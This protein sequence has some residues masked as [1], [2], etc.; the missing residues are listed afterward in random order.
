MQ[1]K[2][3]YKFFIKS[4]YETSDENAIY[5]YEFILLRGMELVAYLNMLKNKHDT[6]EK[7]DAFEIEYDRRMLRNTI[8]TV[9]NVNSN[10]NQMLENYE[11]LV[12]YL[13]K[14]PLNDSN[15]FHVRYFKSN[16]FKS[17]SVIKLCP[18]LA[19][20]NAGR[21]PDDEDIMMS[22][23]SFKG[24]NSSIYN[25]YV[26]AM[27]RA[28]QREPF[29]R[30]M[31]HDDEKAYY[32]IRCAG[33]HIKSS[34]E[35]RVYEN[36]LSEIIDLM[37]K[38]NY[39]YC[40]MIGLLCLNFNLYS[41][42]DVLTIEVNSV[43]SE[44]E[45]DKNSKAKKKAEAELKAAEEAKKRER[46]AERR[47]E[48][49]KL[50]RNIE[51]E[52][53]SAMPYNNAFDLLMALNPAMSEHEHD[54]IE[55]YFKEIKYTLMVDG[56]IPIHH[57]NPKYAGMH[58]IFKEFYAKGDKHIARALEEREKQAAAKKGEKNEEKIDDR[59]NLNKKNTS[60]DTAITCD[61]AAASILNND[62]YY[63]DINDAYDDDET[64]YNSNIFTN[65]YL[66]IKNLFNKIAGR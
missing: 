41:R 44:N 25:A 16:L 49:R 54:S 64:L 34:L 46:R 51:L 5:V 22:D 4:I 14:V 39:K 62:D 1:Y 40:E 29:F 43:E 26:N 12:S 18:D 31:E 21:F 65:I 47:S 2:E 20:H 27:K 15:D 11:D 32:K 48:L 55:T 10:A 17:F 60:E 61:N 7:Y 45:S 23:D 37:R 24:Y 52:P 42:E 38:Y 3:S 33:L 35:L 8:I 53:S 19:K 59:M 56:E 63:D 58:D 50:I 57:V 28:V 6:S 36:F 30:N 9:F 66:G 13:N